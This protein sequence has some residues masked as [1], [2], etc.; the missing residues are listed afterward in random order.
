M[1]NDE[2]PLP[3]IRADVDLRGLE[4]MPL[5]GNHLFG[6][7]FNAAATDSEWRAAI[8]LWWAAW[9]QVP[10]GTLPG[11]DIALCRLADLGRDLK[12]WRSL[13]TRALHGFIECSDSR[14]YHA[15][16]CEQAL[17]AWDKRIKER[18]RKAK[19]R[20]DQDAKKAGR[21]ADG[22]GDRTRDKDGDRDGDSGTPE[23]GR[24]T[25]QRRSGDGDVP[26]D[27][28]QR[29][30]T[31]RDSVYSEA[32]ASGVPPLDPKPLTA[33][34]KLWLLGPPLLGDTDGNRRLLGKLAKDHG[35]EVVVEVL[36]QATL[37]PPQDPKSWLVAACAA[38]GKTKTNG[39]GHHDE[40]EDMLANPKP[41][42]ALEAGFANRFDAEN[43]RC[44]EHNAKQFR[45]GKRI[46][47]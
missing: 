22:D 44:F 33:R 6:S 15:F 10:A 16:L 30:V 26:A 13:K 25:G 29:D 38:R 24:E 39:R 18:E 23:T 35:E 9:N 27:G 36:A 2:R 19:W 34:E 3:L 45:N 8:T 12:S 46:A 14:L 7:E 28:K 1:K 31:G 40:H 4:Y 32:D 5:F 41:Q 20:A 11:D 42:W 37:D 47:S 43:E 21:N 17:I